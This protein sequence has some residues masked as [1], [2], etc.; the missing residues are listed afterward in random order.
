MDTEEFRQRKKIE[1]ASFSLVWT[2]ENRPKT[3]LYWYQFV[4]NNETNMFL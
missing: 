4:Q 3:T 1:K 2:H